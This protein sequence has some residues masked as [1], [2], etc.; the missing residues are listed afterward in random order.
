MRNAKLIKR[1][2]YSVPVRILGSKQLLKGFITKVLEYKAEELNL[3][4]LLCAP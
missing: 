1:L 2:A 4:T 3:Y